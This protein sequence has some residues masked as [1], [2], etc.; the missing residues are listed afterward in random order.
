M[1]IRE[2]HRPDW[3]ISD[4]GNRLELDFYIEEADA[5][6][7]VQGQQHYSFVEFFHRDKSG[8]DKRI[9]YDNAKREICDRRGIR[10]CEISNEDEAIDCV[11]ELSRIKKPEVQI[12]N[13]IVRQVERWHGARRVYDLKIRALHKKLKRALVE[14]SD[15]NSARRIEKI[16]QK[17]AM[18]NEWISQ[19]VVKG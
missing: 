7:E 6:I 10:L 11:L 17:I 12:D 14:T 19:R 9:R 15:T 2:N 3:L 4:D 13:D 8:F 5:A 16:K 1:T 18:W